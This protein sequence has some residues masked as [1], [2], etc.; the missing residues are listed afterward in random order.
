M[1]SDDEAPVPLIQHLNTN[2]RLPPELNLLSGNVSENFKTWKRQVEIYL[3]ASGTTQL[4][5]EIQTATLI[6]C[7]G[8]IY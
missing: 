4:S 6:N 7:G 2:L 8:E 5:K 1:S 3:R